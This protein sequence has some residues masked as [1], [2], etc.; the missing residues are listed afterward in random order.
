MYVTLNTKTDGINSP[1][2]SKVFLQPLGKKSGKER[3][4]T[5]NLNDIWLL[6]FFFL[7]HTKIT[8]PV[9]SITT[10]RSYHQASWHFT[11]AC[12]LIASDWR[13]ISPGLSLLLE[14]QEPVPK[15]SKHGELPSKM[16][17]MPGFLKIICRPGF[18]SQIT[19]IK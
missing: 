16:V 1:T 3:R 19:F 17:G 7:R 2:Y 5:L 11:R 12:S 4:K 15:F 9:S 13:S 8:S 10:K 18:Y 6:N 14:P